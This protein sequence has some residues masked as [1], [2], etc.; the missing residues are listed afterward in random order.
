[1]VRRILPRYVLYNRIMDTEA[2]KSPIEQEQLQTPRDE[3][4]SLLRGNRDLTVL[5]AIASQLNRKTDVREMLQEVLT[6]VTQ[7]FGLQT[8]W[9]WLL[10]EERRTYLAASLALPPYL[11]DHHE[12]MSGSCLC[13]DTFLSGTLAGAANI[14][15]LRCSRLKNAERES[16]PTSWGLRFHASVPIY[17][18]EMALGVLNVASEDWRELSEDELQLLH[19]VSDQIGLAIQ[20][21]RLAAKHMRAATRLATIEERNRLAREIHDTLAQGL[22]AITLHLETADALTEQRPE[23]AHEAIRRAL[24]LARANLE[25][26]R[27]SVIDLRAAP[28]QNRTLPEALHELARDIEQDGIAVTYQ[29]TPSN[30]PLLSP[31]LETG[32]YRIAQEALAN[33]RKHASASS[34]NLALS[35]DEEDNELC[36]YVYDDGRGFQV[37]EAMDMQARFGAQTGHFGLIGMNERVK[38]F[39][40]TLCIDSIPG[41]GT[42]LVVCVPLERDGR[43]DDSHFT[44]R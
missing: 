8:G 36:L 14:D 32:L 9:V 1:M 27:R 33:V 16:D 38:L 17:A 22:A 2:R 31:R 37:D 24:D 42:C 44:G 21:A 34:V 3:A 43:S 4:A 19:I 28:L 6:Q 26:A 30:F 39:G 7:L 18:G 12:R 41:S 15:V 35:L 20:R 5:Y 13:L 29:Y 23:R 11:A 10:D 25:E 40:G